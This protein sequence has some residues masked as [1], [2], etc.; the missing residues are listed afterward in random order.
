MALNNASF[1]DTLR[2]HVLASSAQGAALVTLGAFMRFWGWIFAITTGIIFFFKSE[3]R[4][5]RSRAS[6]TVNDGQ[7]VEEGGVD[8]ED[9]GLGE[10]ARGQYGMA[11]GEESEMRGEERRGEEMGIRE[12]Y[13]AMYQVWQLPCVR[14]LAVVLMTSKVA[15]ATADSV[16]TLKL[17]DKGVSKETMAMLGVA[18]TPIA[19]C[20]PALISKYTSGTRPFGPFLAAFPTRLAMNLAFG[21]ILLTVPQ[22][23]KNSGDVSG[24]GGGEHMSTGTWILV[25]LCFFIS[26]VVQNVMF[27]SQMA[28]FAKVLLLCIRLASVLHPSCI[29]L[30]RLV[31]LCVVYLCKCMCVCVCVHLVYICMYHDVCKYA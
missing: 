12:T 7:G 15:F 10:D 27:V 20:L 1:S 30:V 11:R 4:A 22:S 26:Q 29:R 5:P 2:T 28:F 3:H 6:A 25:L 17:Q 16:T 18:F 24:T 23:Q 13:A 9:G 31:H 8:R 19:L 14:L 21:V